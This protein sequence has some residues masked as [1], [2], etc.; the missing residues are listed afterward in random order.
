MAN[1]PTRI[2]DCDSQSCSFGFIS[3]GLQLK[4]ADLLV[5]FWLV[6]SLKNL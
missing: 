5:F 1:F 2:P 6:K 3:Y 4:I